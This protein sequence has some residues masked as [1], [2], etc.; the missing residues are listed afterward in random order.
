M[1]PRAHQ[2]LGSLILYGCEAAYMQMK[3]LLDP[4]DPVEC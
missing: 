1:L 2:R 3:C 4:K